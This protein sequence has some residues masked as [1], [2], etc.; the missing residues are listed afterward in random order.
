MRGDDVVQLV[1]S[2]YAGLFSETWSQ[3]PLLLRDIVCHQIHFILKKEE[4]WN[5]EDLADS[6]F[7]QKCELELTQMLGW[8]LVLRDF[9]WRGNFKAVSLKSISL[10][11]CEQNHT[12]EGK[13][14][15]IQIC[16]SSELTH[17]HTLMLRRIMCTHAHTH[18]L[19]LLSAL[20]CTLFTVAIYC[21][22]ASWGGKGWRGWA[23]IQA[24][25]NHL[26]WT[27]EAS[28][29]FAHVI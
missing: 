7:H 18:T 12:E 3:A 1:S 8:I 13:C 28:A 10:C 9:V 21:T 11:V 17:V 19:P 2:L 16:W 23:E 26:K 14:A 22:E 20:L 6:I 27:L 29:H 5:K 24:P 25:N 15:G 4:N